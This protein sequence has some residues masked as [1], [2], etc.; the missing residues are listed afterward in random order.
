MQ[1]V[2]LNWTAYRLVPNTGKVLST[3]KNLETKVSGSGGG[4]NIYNRRWI[5]PIKISSETTIHDQIILGNG[6][7]QEFAYQLNGFNLACREGNKLTVLS[8]IK[9]RTN[10]GYYFAIINHTTNQLFYNHDAVEKLC[11]PSAIVY[12]A[13]MLLWLVIC[14]ALGFGFIFCAVAIIISSIAVYFIPLK[15]N[16]K[17]LYEAIG[18]LNLK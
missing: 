11:R 16:Q 4:T 1:T 12:P 5:D 17:K 14:N 3:L 10:R 18:A 9:Q 15:I 8:A 2:A 6:D 13:I 7:G